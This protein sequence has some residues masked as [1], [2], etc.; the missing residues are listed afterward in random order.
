MKNFITSKLLIL[1]FVSTTIMFT[2]IATN[3]SDISNTV[4]DAQHKQKIQQY[5]DKI[6]TL[7]KQLLF[8]NEY[9]LESS[10]TNKATYSNSLTL[11]NNEIEELREEIFNYLETIPSISYQNRDVAL[12][13]NSLTFLKNA[14]YQL[15]LLGD[16]TSAV[17]KNLL[18]EDFY[19]F[20]R[21]SN[22]TLSTLENIIA[23][24]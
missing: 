6:Q 2:G 11:A 7:Q 19:L 10:P 9:N 8:L 20:M 22:D 12:A 1:L 15:I 3:A 4:N 5:I 17:D 21:L 16:T 14:L 24:D 13:F 18:L 23:R